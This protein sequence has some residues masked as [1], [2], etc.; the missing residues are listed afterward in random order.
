[1]CC[2]L[3]VTMK[4]KIAAGG[5]TRVTPQALARALQ[6]FDTFCC[7]SRAYVLDK[8]PAPHATCE[9]RVSCTMTRSIKK[10]KEQA[11]VQKARTYQ[12]ESARAEMSQTHAAGERRAAQEAERA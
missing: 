5:S 3:F 10:G 2:P 9:E 7:R 4:V 6:N 1:M 11:R 8:E 12:K